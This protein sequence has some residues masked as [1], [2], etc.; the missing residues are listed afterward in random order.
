MESHEHILN[1][2][3][4]LY[5]HLINNNNWDI[6]SYVK[7]MKF[8]N[9]EEIIEHYKYID[10]DICKKSMLFLMRNEINPIW[11]DP[12]NIEGACYSYK[13]S[14]KIICNV[15]KNISYNLVAENLIDKNENIINGIS[16]SPKKFFC[17]LKIW[18]NN[19]NFDN[20]KFK[21]DNL[22]NLDFIFKLHK[23]V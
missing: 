3:W 5:Y 4:T 11:E 7:L 20:L 12:H 9:L 16:I 8:K 21:N 18:I 19:K 23:E 13:I 2:S 6:K 22:N 17:I 1:D 14:N 15:W 10:E